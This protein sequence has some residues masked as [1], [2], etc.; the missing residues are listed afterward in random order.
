MYRTPAPSGRK[1]F[2]CLATFRHCYAC[3]AARGVRRCAEELDKAWRA[4]SSPAGC[5][6]SEEGVA[7]VDVR[8]ARPADY[9]RLRR[10]RA[11]PLAVGAYRLTEFRC[12]TASAR[13]LGGSDLQIVKAALENRT[14]W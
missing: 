2:R 10:R 14:R 1:P 7:L 12:R 6:A 13:L 3:N 8:G 5:R 11:P 4:D 9:R